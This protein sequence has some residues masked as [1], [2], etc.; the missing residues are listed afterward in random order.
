VEP[1][2]EGQDVRGYSELEHSA[3]DGVQGKRMWSAAAPDP[4]PQDPTQPVAGTIEVVDGVETQ[5]VDLMCERFASGAH[6]W[7]R[8][9]FRADRP[10]EVALA[11]FAHPDS[12]RLERCILTAT[13]G[14][15]A[16]LRVLHLADGTRRPAELWPGFVG[17]EFTEHARFGLAVLQRGADGAAVVHAEPD[18]VDHAAARYGDDT[19]DHWRYY[20][21]RARQTWIAE[22]PDPALEL[23][24]NA[25]A[26]YWASSSPIPGGPSFENFELTEP[27]R[28]G[29]VL[30]F[31]VEPL[32]P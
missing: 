13:M 30:R 15:F 14:N 9:R 26:T 10:H 28:Q 22:D 27:F 5:R 25:R 32:T 20:G 7:V 8:A 6:V 24:V 18:E 21:S 31:R 29:W 1:V 17:P 11:A 19:A 12:A 4:T 2:V 23:L 3:L 16:R